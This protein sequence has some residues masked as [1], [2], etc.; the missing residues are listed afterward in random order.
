MNITSEI[1][2][3]PRAGGNLDVLQGSP[4]VWLEEE[5][6]EVILS[7]CWIIQKKPCHSTASAQCPNSLVRLGWAAKVQGD[8]GSQRSNQGRYHDLLMDRSRPGL[9]IG[10]E[11]PAEL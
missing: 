6:E 3:T 9:K 7:L 4:V 8:G 10:I 5:V 1:R 11:K 2:D